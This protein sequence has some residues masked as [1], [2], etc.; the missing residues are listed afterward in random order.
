MRGLP[1]A[2]DDFAHAAHGLRVGRDHAERA[3]VV[4]NVFGG[5]GLATNARLGE[6][7]VLGDAGVEVVAHHQHV[8]VLVD[9]C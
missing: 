2:H 9:A 5:D 8:E 1:G 7:D 3:E 6:R 4:Q